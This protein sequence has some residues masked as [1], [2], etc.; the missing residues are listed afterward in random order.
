M[1]SIFLFQ[2]PIM[3]GDPSDLSGDLAAQ[4]QPRGKDFHMPSDGFKSQLVHLPAVWPWSNYK[5]EQK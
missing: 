4:C 2:A 3:S 5:I 1:A